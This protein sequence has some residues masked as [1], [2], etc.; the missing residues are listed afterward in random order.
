MAVERAVKGMRPSEQPSRI[1]TPD[2]ATVALL[3]RAVEAD[4]TAPA[5]RLALRY[6][7]ADGRIDKR[8]KHDL[9]RVIR[10][11]VRRAALAASLAAASGDA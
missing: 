4:P 1:I 5:V 10:R 7:E 9:R 2:P 3:T 8:T 11:A 6:L